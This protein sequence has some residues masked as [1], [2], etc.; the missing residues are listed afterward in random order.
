MVLRRLKQTQYFAHVN[1]Y[2]TWR[3]VTL[4]NVTLTEFTKAV[5]DSI[6]GIV[7]VTL[8]HVVPLAKRPISGPL[9]SNVRP[10]VMDHT[11]SHTTSD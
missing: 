3:Y 1:V 4:H 5:R 11:R 7:A 8:A 6:P 2:V 10:S 9:S